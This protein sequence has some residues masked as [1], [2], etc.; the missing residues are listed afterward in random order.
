MRA[1]LGWGLAAVECGLWLLLAAAS[2]HLLRLAAWAF[3]QPRLSGGGLSPAGSDHL[4]TVQLP[5]RNERDVAARLLNAVAALDWPR[6]QIQILDDSDD[7]TSQILDD[8][9]KDLRTRGLDVEVL[10]RGD[11]K[12]FK[13]GNLQHGLASARG[14]FLLILDADSQPA[15]DLIRR[16]IA[17]LLRDEQLGFVQARWT[18]VNERESLLT[19]V[20]A[21]I[22]HALFTVEQARLSALGK[23]LQFNGTAGLWRKRALE[24]AGGWLGANASVTED[25]DVSYRAQQKGFRGLT[26]PSVTVATELPS[27]MSAFRTQQSRWVRGAAETLRTQFRGVAGSLGMLAHLARHARQPLLLALTL[28]LPAAA[29]GFIAPPPSLPP[30]WPYV[31]TFTFVAVAAYHAAALRRLGRNP[32]AALYTAPAVIVLSVGLSFALTASLLAGLAGTKT[33]WARTPKRGDAPKASYAPSRLPR[34]IELLLG[35]AN[36]G[37]AVWLAWQGLW[38]PAVSLFF[39]L[40]LGLLWIG[41]G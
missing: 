10:R 7:E 39:F 12:G 17:P 6:L 8:T 13:A 26:D 37:V 33:D 21:I 25:L 16:L 19:R 30:L 35:A 31:L 22:L 34:P 27:T 40:A 20:Q 15:P 23:P 18:F 5:I 3:S 38:I 29:L 14:E 11:R 4:V 41:L 28:A 1:T 24:A 36:L 9:A 2:F 32:L